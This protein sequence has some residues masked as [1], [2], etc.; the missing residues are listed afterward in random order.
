MNF[1]ISLFYILIN[2][3]NFLTSTIPLL[4]LSLLNK[5][6]SLIFYD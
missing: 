6:L 1:F 4:R 2:L 5:D 3:K